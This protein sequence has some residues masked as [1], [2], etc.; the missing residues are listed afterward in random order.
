MRISG[1]TR[2]PGHKIGVSGAYAGG[3]GARE[4]CA[5][6]SHQE[7]RQE[8]FA[9]LEELA[10]YPVEGIEMDFA[11][12][13]F[14]FKPEEIKTHAPVMTEF[15]RSISKMVRAKGKNRIV[16][17]RVFPTESM[18]LSLGLDVRA[19]LSE[20]LVDYVAPLFYGFFALDP[21]MPFESLVE[22]AHMSGGEIYPILQ[23]YFLRHEDSA[24]PAMFRA[25]IANYWAKGADG[26]IAWF[27]HWPPGEAER[28][29]L[30]DIGDPDVVREK[31][32]HY[33]LPP[34][35]QDA[36][37]LGYDQPLPLQ[38]EKANPNVS[39]QIPFYVADD[40]GSSRVARVR[41]RLKILNLVTA[42]RFKV[43]LNGRDLS[44]EA[45]RRTSHRYE[46]QWLEYTLVRVRPER[47]PNNLT[48]SLESRPEGL[49]GG[50]TVDLVELLVEY[51]HPHAPDAR[52]EF[53]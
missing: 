14:Y 30:T 20:K 21:N 29:I 33:V 19:W 15:V 53:L 48:V 52:P 26:L 27:L 39:A 51:D 45:L 3:A 1:K 11:F 37:A 22:A 31:D 10:G 38:L 44:S 40:P 35:Q 16:G 47:G 17:A 7:V 12:T 8:R 50:V 5:D 42:D 9:W 46:F 34:R 6:F 32:K 4:D 49:E 23:P 36:A 13:P 24:T 43:K 28:S 25:A 41:L 18:N 2:N